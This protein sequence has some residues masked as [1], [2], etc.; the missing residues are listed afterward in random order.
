MRGKLKCQILKTIRKR[1]AVMNDIEYNP[2]ECTFEGECTGTCPKCE[3][4]TDNLMS[5]LKRKERWDNKDIRIDVGTIMDLNCIA[6][7]KIDTYEEID[8]KDED[9]YFCGYEGDCD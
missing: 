9:L 5:E 3:E 6:M 1:I 4:E 7:E 8:M 2:E